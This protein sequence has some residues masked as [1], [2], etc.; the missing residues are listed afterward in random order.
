MI[1]NIDIIVGSRE[2]KRRATI[3]RA[4]TRTD[5]AAAPVFTA[6]ND[7]NRRSRNG[8][9]SE[10]SDFWESRQQQHTEFSIQKNFYTSCRHRICKCPQLNC[11]GNRV[12]VNTQRLFEIG[13]FSKY[14][15]L[16][17]GVVAACL[18][19]PPLLYSLAAIL[20][21]TLGRMGAT[22][23][24]R[25]SVLREASNTQQHTT[26]NNS[27]VAVTLSFS[28]QFLWWWCNH[29]H[30]AKALEFRRRHCTREF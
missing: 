24:S 28:L 29:T 4:A 6:A 9:R 10:K 23:T 1:N 21:A 14:L 7:R 20:E 25:Q 16:S 19:A 12:F 11:A 26:H 13:D 17:R 5:W 27:T 2:E 8:S 22:R 18:V 30:T 3:S 15:G